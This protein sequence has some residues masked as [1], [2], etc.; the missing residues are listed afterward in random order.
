MNVRILPSARL[1]GAEAN[2]EAFI[3]KARG[4]AAFG[5]VRFDEP[6]WTVKCL[7]TGR[8]SSAGRGTNKIYFTQAKQGGRG[9]EGREVLKQ[10]FADFLKA[11]VRLR[12]DASAKHLGDH[13]AVIR[14]GRYLY[15]ETE[16]IGHN[17]CLLLPDHFLRAAAAS[18]KVD[19]P[20]TAYQLG[21]KLAE[22]ADWAN[23][24]KVTRVRINFRNPN[25]RVDDSNVRIGA[26]AEARRAKK[27][28]G[29]A[30]LDALAQLSNL[31]SDDADILQMRTIELL[32]CGGWRI[33]ELLTIPENCEVEEEAT[34]NG[35]AVLG[36]DGRPVVRYGIRYFG[37]K[38]APPLPKWIPTP[39]VDVAKRA[40]TD[41]RRITQPSRDT[42]LWMRS[43]PGRVPAPGLVHCHP[44]ETV[45]M[46]RLET[47][48]GLHPNKGLIW[49]RTWG[50]ELRGTRMMEARVGDIANALVAKWP[51]IPAESPL[52]LHEHMFITPTNMTHAGRVAIPGSV[53]FLTDGIIGGFL[54]GR[55]TL[56]SVFER[57]G[58]ID[59]QGKPFRMNSHQFRHWLNTLA[60]EGGMSDLEI[61]RWSGRKDLAQNAAYDHVTGAQ[62]AKRVRALFEAGEIRGPLAKLH[63]RLPPRDRQRFLEAQIATAHVT[64]IGLC[65]H[66][67]SLVP[68]PHHG[69]CA[70]C[71][72]HIV[73]KGDAKQREEAE[74]LLDET[75]F[76]LA[77]AQA[78]AADE[79]YGAGRWAQSHE[80]MAR[81]LRAIMAIHND[82]EISDGTLVQA[83][84]ASSS[85][86]ST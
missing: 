71:G 33:N 20:S 17:P 18:R 61:A 37:E 27:L 16:A 34:A 3:A 9:L 8:S 81:G 47:A 60:H 65:V 46:R 11:V 38:G 7:K 44:D 2:L 24:H 35:E 77:K 19:S 70:D 42:V 48:F 54:G 26:E 50:V 69:A 84:V 72:E 64:D 10:P 5:P 78:E 32:V 49:C 53:R 12:E 51:V 63:E 45:T 56:R 82:P 4:V 55:Q 40:V 73:V 22:I 57:Y 74:R 30:A 85:E 14:A 52:A 68:C 79:T 76:L 15:A 67:W 1:Q 58:M 83:G 25:S 23:R 62:L 41:I 28:P 59:G 43:N 39:L 31:V 75:E 21:K 80:R 29:E 86:D 36:P 13:A 6:M 66:D